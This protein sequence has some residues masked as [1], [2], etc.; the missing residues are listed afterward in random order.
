MSRFQLPFLYI[1]IFISAISA[2]LL[3]IY[4]NIKGI[5]AVYQLPKSPKLIVVLLHG[6]SHSATDFYPKNEKCINCIGLPVEVSIVTELLTNNAIPLAISS[7]NRDHK[8]WSVEEDDTKLISES[9]LYFL[10]HIVRD[11]TLPIYIFGASSGGSYASYYSQHASQHGV[12]ISGVIVQISPLHINTMPPTGYNIP[13]AII[14]MSK[15]KRMSKYIRHQITKLAT[16]FPIQ[17]YI[18]HPIPLSIQHFSPILN[19]IDANN[20]INALYKAGLLNDTYYLLHDPREVRIMTPSWRAIAQQ[21]LP[22]DIISKDNN[23]TAD[24][25]GISELMNVAYAS[26]EISAQ[27]VIGA[28]QWC[29]ATHTS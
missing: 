20:F 3:G 24:V 5:E 9:I 28:I 16:Y 12:T 26:H 13:N 4:D 11:T 15:D 21:T 8:C 25:S 27:Y 1:A 23:L 17:E 18:I 22:Q 14:H 10:Q 29:S 7:R 2:S 19:S 6:C